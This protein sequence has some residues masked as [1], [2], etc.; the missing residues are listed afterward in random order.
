MRVQ[1]P[2]PAPSSAGNYSSIDR[3]GWT[4]YV[5]RLL[6]ANEPDGVSGEREIATDRHFVCHREQS[7]FRSTAYR[8]ASPGS[9]LNKKGTWGTTV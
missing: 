6:R 9:G 8:P 3:Q 5:G 4:D 1:F 7:S 2:L